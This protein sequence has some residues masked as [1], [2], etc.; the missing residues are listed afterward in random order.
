MNPAQQRFGA[1]D[2]ARG[3][4]DLRL[5]QQAQFVTLDGG[6]QSALDQHAL[7]HLLVQIIGKE[8]EVVAPQVLGAVHRRV[9]ML[10]ELVHGGGI[11]RVQ[12]QADGRGNER[13]LPIGL[14][15][16][17]DYRVSSRRSWTAPEDW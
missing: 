14:K 12:A 7:M 17:R 1:V 9:G 6:T 8:L 4:I 15:R 16:R 2:L 5:I 11:V 3:E 10:D 13:L